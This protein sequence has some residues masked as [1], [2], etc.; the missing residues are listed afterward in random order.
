MQVVVMINMG[1]GGG[2]LTQVVRVVVVVMVTM[3]AV[4][5]QV[6]IVSGDYE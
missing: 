6:M 2:R 3:I 1:D 5:V 4:V